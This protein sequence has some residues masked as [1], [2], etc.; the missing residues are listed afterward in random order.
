MMVYSGARR[1]VR[2]PYATSCRSCCQKSCRV[3]CSSTSWASVRHSARTVVRSPNRRMA[4]SR[5][6]SGESP[7]RSS[8]L[9]SISICSVSSS[10]TSSSTGRRQNRRAPERSSCRIAGSGGAEDAGHRFHQDV[11]VRRLRPHFGATGGCQGIDPYAFPDVRLAPT[12][13]DPPTLL[14][15][16]QRWVERSFLDAQHVIGC[17]LDPPRDGVAV[18]RTPGQGFEDEKVERSLE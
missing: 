3:I 16:V 12:R 1:S 15:P 10:S 8:R 13:L 17:L 2:V 9:T 4:A 5:A 14:H 6:A 18:T 7:S 11:P